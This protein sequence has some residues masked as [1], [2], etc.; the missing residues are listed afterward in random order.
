MGNMSNRAKKLLGFLANENK[1]Y[2]SHVSTLSTES[3]KEHGRKKKLTERKK[4]ILRTR[5]AAGDLTKVH[6]F[7][8]L[9]LKCIS[10]MSLL[11][12]CI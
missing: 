9:H 3:Y 8:F 4:K 7:D 10:S 6:H 5:K 11:V 12:L 2:V 1:L